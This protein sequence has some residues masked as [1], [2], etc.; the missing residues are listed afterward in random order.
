MPITFPSDHAETSTYFSLQIDYV[1][2]VQAR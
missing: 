1:R 2:V